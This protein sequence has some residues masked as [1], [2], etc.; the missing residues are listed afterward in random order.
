MD[1]ESKLIFEKYSNNQL[2]NEAAPALVL[3]AIAAPLLAYV[4]GKTGVTDYV[5]KVFAKSFGIDLIS[6]LNL[7][8]VNLIKYLEPTGITNWPDVDKFTEIYEQNPTDENLWKLYEALF[9]SFPIVGKY[10]KGIKG[11][12]AGS[13]ELGILSRV[14]IT[15]VR[16]AIEL[17]LRNPNVRYKLLK[18]LT[19]SQVLKYNKLI[20]VVLGVSLAR[21]LGIR[22]LATGA[23]ML[24]EDGK[25]FI[26]EFAKKIGETP[27]TDESQDATMSEPGSSKE[28]PIF[29]NWSQFSKGDTSLNKDE[30]VGKVYQSKSNQLYYKIV[31]Q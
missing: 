22:F 31:D 8:G 25:K 18:Y 29:V 24:T 27:F 17:A 3:A 11:L 19:T 21:M 20:S 23:V 7:P 6:F 26:E 10:A 2:V 5:N 9:Y 16:K 28:D 30:Y 1:K 15:V 14:G 4:S 13:K 12:T